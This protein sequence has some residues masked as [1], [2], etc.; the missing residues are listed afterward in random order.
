LNATVTEIDSSGKQIRLTT[1]KGTV[2]S[3][4]VIVAVST[5]ILGGGNIRFTPGLPDWKQRAIADLPLG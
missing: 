5:G 1:P 2:T 3:K 4:A